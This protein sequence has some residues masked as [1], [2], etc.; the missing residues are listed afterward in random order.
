MNKDYFSIEI[1]TDNNNPMTEYT[2]KGKTYVEA[3][4]NSTFNIKISNSTPAKILAVPTVDGVSVIDG[5]EGK[6]SSPGYVIEPYG[7]VIIDGWRVGNNNIRKFQFSKKKASYSN[8]RGFGSANNGIIG[9]AIFKEK[10]YRDSP[11][12]STT[13]PWKSYPYDFPKT[14]LGNI[15]SVLTASAGN[16]RGMTHNSVSDSFGTKMGVEQY[17][18]S[19]KVTFIRRNQPSTVLELH[20][21][22][23]RDLEAI[24]V[25]KRKKKIINNAEAFPKE[26]NNRDGY[27]QVA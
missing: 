26:N 10:V 4:K 11:N 6:Y 13:P 12:I 3:R 7:N 14:F 17:S 2:G 20:Y 15:S 23:R 8:K 22:S 9:V 24:G 19:T 1:L 18:H 25:I 5:K 16:S 27:C 21:L